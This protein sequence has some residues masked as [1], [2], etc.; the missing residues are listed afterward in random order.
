LRFSVWR[1]CHRA[2]NVHGTPLKKCNCC[3]LLRRLTLF[4]RLL[5]SINHFQHRRNPMQLTN[6]PVCRQQAS[7]KA[8]ACPSCGHPIAA[9]PRGVQLFFGLIFL[10]ALTVAALQFAAPGGNPILAS[11]LGIIAMQAAAQIASR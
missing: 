2:E 6:C 10:G 11:L 9:E 1:S 7:P 8:K 5:N 4:C 3:E